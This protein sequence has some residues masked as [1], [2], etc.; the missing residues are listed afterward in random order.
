MAKVPVL[1]YG[2]GPIGLGIAELL[3]SRSGVGVIG[4]IDID[5]SKIGADLGELAGGR[6]VGVSVTSEVPDAPAGGVAIHAT[7]SRLVEVAPQ[8]ESLLAKGWNVVSTC[9]Q[10]VHPYSVDLATSSRLDKVARSQER[11]VLGS[12]INPGFL[13]DVLALTLTGV[14]TSVRAVRVSRVVDTNARRIPLQS[15]AGVGLTRE[16]FEARAKVAGIGHVGLRQSAS[17]IAARLN[18][19][20]DEYEEVIEP[21]IAHAPVETGLGVIAAG[22]V[23]GQRQTVTVTSAGR[24]VVRYSLE[25]SAGSAA[26]DAI[27]IEGTPA[28]HQRIE[29]GVNGDTGTVAVI[30]NL[31]PVVAAALPGLLTM[32]DIMQLAAMVDGDGVG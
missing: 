20:V 17:L 1:C 29:G 28:V 11:T 31:V 15:K 7:G 5:P 6:R 24:E 32:A 3:L 14:C 27:D 21:V 22:A 19:R 13:M 2:L 10:L 4:A 25:M 23:I 18:W 8:L 12:G 26:G 9:E 30:A 16:E